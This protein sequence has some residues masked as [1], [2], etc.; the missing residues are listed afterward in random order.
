[1][2]WAWSLW[3]HLGAQE[4]GTEPGS[5]RWADS[6][7]GAQSH[8]S[9]VPPDPH[10]HG[11]CA[12]PLSALHTHATAPGADRPGAPAGPAAIHS[13]RPEAHRH[14]LPVQ[15]P[16]RQT[17]GGNATRPHQLSPVGPRSQE[18]PSQPPK[19]QAPQWSRA[20]STTEPLC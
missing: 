7:Q 1:M 2:I 4:A 12:L 6:A 9:L 3:G 18:A 20:G 13:L 16:L 14:A 19:T 10:S 17:G 15:T 5:L 11:L 8:L